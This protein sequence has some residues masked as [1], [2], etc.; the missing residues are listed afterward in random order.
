MRETRI[1]NRVSRIPIDKLTAHPLF[2]ISSGQAGTRRSLSGDRV[3][4]SK[5]STVKIAGWL[6]SSLAMKPSMP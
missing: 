2:A 4:A 3:T 1:K 6:S 5:S